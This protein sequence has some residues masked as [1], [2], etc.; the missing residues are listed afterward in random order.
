V[1]SDGLRSVD[2]PV[3][4][5]LAMDDLINT[6]EQQ[7]QEEIAMN[8][9]GKKKQQFTQHKSF[10]NEDRVDRT[11]GEKKFQ[12][13]CYKCHEPG[14]KASECPLKGSKEGTGKEK[15]KYKKRSGA[16]MSVA[17]QRPIV[18]K[19]YIDGCCS[20]DVSPDKNCMTEFTQKPPNMTITFANNQAMESK[21]KGN[22][23]ITLKGSDDARELSD[24]LYVLD[25]TANLLSVSNTVKKGYCMFFVTHTCGVF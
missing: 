2:E 7:N 6:S 25:A 15:G 11:K 16:M 3:G 4:K 22:V 17:A 10:T 9:Q 13:K 24:V 23:P 5:L 19:W 21:G 20:N 1:E 12:F 8:T 14:H 18:G